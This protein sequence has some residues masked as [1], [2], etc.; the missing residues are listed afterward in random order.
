MRLDCSSARF[1][2]NRLKGEKCSGGKLCKERLTVFLCVFMSGEMEKRVVIGKEVKP[3]CF[4]NLDI[5]KR[6]V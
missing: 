6:S 2:I 3:R 5:R 1:R 4:L